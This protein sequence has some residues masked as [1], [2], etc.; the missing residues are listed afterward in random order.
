MD[1]WFMVVSQYRAASLSTFIHL[2]WTGTLGTEPRDVPVL[3]RN[4]NKQLDALCSDQL[5]VVPTSVLQSK[6]NSANI[7]TLPSSHSGDTCSPNAS[8]FTTLA[9]TEVASH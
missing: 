6:V 1:G 5:N 3:R 7:W 4:I 2:F 9:P 8:R